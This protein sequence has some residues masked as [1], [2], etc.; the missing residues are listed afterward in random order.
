MTVHEALVAYTQSNKYR[1]TQKHRMIIGVL[2]ARKFRSQFGLNYEIPTTL[3]IEETGSYRVFDYPNEF[4]FHI[5]EII[6]DYVIRLRKSKP[7]V[8]NGKPLIKP[9]PVT[10]P[11]SYSSDPQKKERKRKPIKKPHFSGKKLINNK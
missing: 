3:S 8:K 1:F 9:E 11:I 7:K 2:I 10:T 6:H 4:V 5:E